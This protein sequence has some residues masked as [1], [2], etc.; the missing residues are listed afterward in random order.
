MWAAGDA[1]KVK[2]LLSA[3]ADVNARAN[4][5]R[6]ALMVAAASAG[7]AESVRA[8]LDAGADAKAR[9]ASGGGAV[10]SAP[11]CQSVAL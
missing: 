4:S 6:T 10:L 9:D 3:G 11:S 8:M 2:L 5:G 7:N 1:A